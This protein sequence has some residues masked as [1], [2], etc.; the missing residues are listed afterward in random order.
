MS[1]HNRKR[2]RASSDEAASS[3]KK[4]RASPSDE[5]VKIIRLNVGGERMETTRA[6][7][8]QVSESLLGRMFD[9]NSP[10]GTP[11]QD[12]DGYF[13]LDAD[14]EAFRVVL[15]FLRRGAL[16]EGKHL[17]PVL[18]NK[19][20]AEA[21]FFGLTALAQ[22]CAEAEKEAENE[23]EKEAENE[24]DEK[25]DTLTALINISETLEVI[26]DTLKKCESRQEDEETAMHLEEIAGSIKKFEE[27]VEMNGFQ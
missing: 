4:S 9:E 23:A 15:N 8:T 1:T 21:D 25:E 11:R 14:S 5:A 7:L 6:T 3:Q 22:A 27:Y 20:A 26:S 18:R 24:K 16:V 13:F 10:F 2:S 19:V 17:A 12:A